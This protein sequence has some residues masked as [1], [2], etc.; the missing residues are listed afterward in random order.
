[1]L[2]IP[3]LLPGV[4]LRYLGTRLPCYKDLLPPIGNQGSSCLVQSHQKE[5]EIR[6]LRHNAVFLASSEGAVGG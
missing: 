4:L 2:Y 5:R 6:A 1:M 3:N